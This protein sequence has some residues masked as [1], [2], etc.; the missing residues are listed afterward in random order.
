MTFHKASGRL[1]P[2]AEASAARD[3][4]QPADASA[5]RTDAV[6]TEVG[7]DAGSPAPRTADGDEPQST[8]L[9]KLEF[10]TMTAPAGLGYQPKNVGAI[11]VAD[12]SGKLL[13]TLELWAETRVP[14]LV[15]YNKARAGARID[16]MAGATLP[17]HRSHQTSWD[18]KDRSGATVPPGKYRLMLELNDGEALSKATAVEFD[19]SAGATTLTPPDAE[20]YKNMR[21]QLE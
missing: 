7:A 17:N 9:S 4:A 21:L 18:F 12:G 13:K 1:G 11:W 19:T 8:A 10:E 6:L 14:F 3:A 20:C 16:V 5:S 2:W 15:A